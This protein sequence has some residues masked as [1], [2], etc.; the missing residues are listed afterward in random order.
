[1]M[2]ASWD[3]RGL[4]LPGP[5]SPNTRAMIL[6]RY[7]TRELRLP[8]PLPPQMQAMIHASYVAREPWYTRA[9]IA[10]PSL[11]QICGL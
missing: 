7:D 8:P 3:T 4:R 2:H 11:P 1:M 6:A 10:G 9:M 5:A